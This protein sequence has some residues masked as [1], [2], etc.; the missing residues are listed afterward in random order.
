[1]PSA[2]RRIRDHPNYNRWQGGLDLLADVVARSPDEPES[3]EQRP[4]R[5]CP[6]DGAADAHVESAGAK[7][8]ADATAPT[9]ESKRMR[10]EML[11]ESGAVSEALAMLDRPEQRTQPCPCPWYRNSSRLPWPR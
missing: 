2:F 3:T 7:R 10:D 11:V 1:M 8:E 9:R 4:S 5:P 6:D